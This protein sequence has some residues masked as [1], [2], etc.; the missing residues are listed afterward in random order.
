MNFPLTNAFIV[1]CKFGYVVN[2]FSLNSRKSLI[3]FF[4]SSLTQ[5]SLSRDFSFQ[6]CVGFPVLLVLLKSSFNP[7]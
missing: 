1:F 2:S 7:G 3:S 5:R 6:E 4:V